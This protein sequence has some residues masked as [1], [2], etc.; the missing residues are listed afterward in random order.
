ME[1]PLKSAAADYSEPGFPVADCLKPAKPDQQ[2]WTIKPQIGKPHVA[3]FEPEQPVDLRGALLTLTIED[4]YA[5]S[6]GQV[7][8]RFRFSATDQALP[9]P[10]SR[11]RSSSALARAEAAGQI[12]AGGGGWRTPSFLRLPRSR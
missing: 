6:G 7:L 5:P 3:I 4:R 1:I 10:W 9:V 8:G 2:G 12:S 11:S